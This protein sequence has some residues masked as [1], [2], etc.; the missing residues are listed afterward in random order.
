ML[1]LAVSSHSP[2]HEN[3]FKAFFLELIILPQISRSKSWKISGVFFFFVHTPIPEAALLLTLGFP[4]CIEE[5]WFLEP[6]VPGTSIISSQFGSCVIYCTKD[7]TGCIGRASIIVNWWVLLPYD[8]SYTLGPWNTPPGWYSLLWSLLRN[9]TSRK[10]I[11]WS[12]PHHDPATTM[13][14]H[15]SEILNTAAM[16]I[17]KRSFPIST[18]GK[19]YT[20]A[21][22]LFSCRT[23]P[24]TNAA[25]LAEWSC[26]K[27]SSPVCGM[28]TWVDAAPDVCC[29][30]HE[31]SRE[32]SKVLLPS[33]IPKT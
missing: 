11:T 18:E 5:T 2:C 12:N 3:K 6:D 7:D 25:I 17:L 28:H 30:S 29:T 14:N 16:Q 22:F 24:G 15:Q 31:L 27:I 33:L 20:R 10:K 26:P 21:V 19:F 13:I 4:H 1:D 32:H 9:R 23:L 8:R